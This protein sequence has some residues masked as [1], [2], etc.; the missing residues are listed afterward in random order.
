MQEIEA[1][2]NTIATQDKQHSMQAADPGQVAEFERLMN[3]TQ[4]GAEPSA[5]P[6]MD[7]YLPTAESPMQVASSNLLKIGTEASRAFRSEIKHFDARLDTIDVSDPNAMIE[8]TK[9]QLEAFGSLYQV[10][11][12]SG[13]ASQVNRGFTTLFHMQN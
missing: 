4:T 6:V 9:L 7:Q 2:A 13:L 10:E 5:G 12:A 11:L 3:S 1:I 8:V